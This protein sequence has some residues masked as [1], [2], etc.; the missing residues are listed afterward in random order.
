[1]G[2]KAGRQA[3]LGGAVSGGLGLLCIISAIT[4]QVSGGSGVLIGVL[5]LGLI[6][7]GIGVL[8]GVTARRVTRARRLVFDANGVRWDDP[9]GKAWAV[10]WEELSNVTIS[11]TKQRRVQ[12]TD[13]VMRRILVRLDLFPADPAFR[14]RH[15]EMEHL[16][17]FHRVRNGYRLPLGHAPDF[18]PLIQDG[19]QRFRPQIYGGIHDEGLVVGLR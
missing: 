6:F 8:V 10:R 3:L 18:I 4:G 13:Y 2:K 9:Q 19:M 14:Q 7:L 11:R 16:W 12:L 17:E 5:V 1:V 15:P